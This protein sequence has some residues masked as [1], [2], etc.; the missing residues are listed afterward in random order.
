MRLIELSRGSLRLRLAPEIGGSILAFD[1]VGGGTVA[2]MRGA[3]SAT[4]TV[5]DCAS[6]PLVPYSN[7]IRGGCF[8]FRGREAVQ[9]PNMAGDPSPL[10]GQGWLAPWSTEDSDENSAELAFLHEPG[11]W[12]WAYEAR[13][14]FRLDADGLDLTLTCRNLSDDA[15]PCGL[16]LHPYFPCDASTR[17]DTRVTGAW[18]ID[19]DVLPVDLVR[20]TGRYD[21]SDRAICGQHLDNGFEGW[22]GEATITTNGVPTVRIRSADAQRFQVYSPASGGFFVAEPVQAANAALNEAE[23]EWPRLG[24]AVLE[25]GE[26]ARLHT[27]FDVVAA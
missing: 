25:P 22:G 8:T 26:T 16:G 18:T 17:L 12:P 10:H 24:L 7:R 27:R 13:Q 20:A 1:R 14:V 4:A 2:L 3:E 19:A 9:T 23:S 6:F 21:L 11:E 5:L 15:M